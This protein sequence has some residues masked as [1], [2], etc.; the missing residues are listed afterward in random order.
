LLNNPRLLGLGGEEAA[1]SK[2]GWF[3]EG[4]AW[5]RPTSRRRKTDQR[6]PEIPCLH[7]P[8]DQG[9][10]VLDLVPLPSSSLAEGFSLGLSTPSLPALLRLKLR[11]PTH[12]PLTAEQGHISFRKYFFNYKIYT[13]AEEMNLIVQWM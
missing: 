2:M 3:S 10:L 6:L 13:H 1:C 8:Q 4:G 5:T 11:G 7:L 9:L 12:L